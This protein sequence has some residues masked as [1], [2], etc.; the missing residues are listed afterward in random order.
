MVV[1][2]AFKSFLMLFF[3][4]GLTREHRDIHPRPNTSELRWVISDLI[5]GLDTFKPLPEN[6]LN[7]MLRNYY[8]ASTSNMIVPLR[9]DGSSQTMYEWLCEQADL[10]V[11][12][13]VNVFTFTVDLKQCWKT[14]SSISTITET[15]SRWNQNYQSDTAR[16]TDTVMATEIKQENIEMDEPVNLTTRSAIL[17]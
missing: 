5:I 8:S 3:C 13:R 15:A 1:N 11:V 14:N 2:F 7:F 16:K 6:T 17:E 9:D 4:F 12:N 10:F